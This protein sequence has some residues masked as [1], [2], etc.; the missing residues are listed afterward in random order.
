M[1][2]P[3]GP[4]HTLT[5]AVA[6]CTGV[7]APWSRGQWHGREGEKGSRQRSKGRGTFCKILSITYGHSCD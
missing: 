6:P 4:A 7:W 5:L 1:P 3:P 2:C